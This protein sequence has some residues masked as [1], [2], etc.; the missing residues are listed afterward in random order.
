MEGAYGSV[1]VPNFPRSLVDRCGHM[2]GQGQMWVKVDAE[3]LVTV[4]LRDA[5]AVDEHIQKWN[6]TVTMAQN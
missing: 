4:Y 5:G 1:A 6:S 2:R 3:M